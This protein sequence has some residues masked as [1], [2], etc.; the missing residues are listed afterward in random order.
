ML[1]KNK[2]LKKKNSVKAVLKKKKLAYTRIDM[3]TMEPIEGFKQIYTF[4]RIP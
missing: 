2:K 4:R 1:A 3:S